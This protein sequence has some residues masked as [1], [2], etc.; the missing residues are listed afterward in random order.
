MIRLQALSRQLTQF[1]S[2]SAFSN[3]TKKMSTATIDTTGFKYNH[4][5]IRIKDPKVSVPFYEKNFGMKLYGK[6]SFT[7]F[8]FDVYYL[9]IESAVPAGTP[10]Y[11]R[12][13]LLELTHNYGT[14]NDEAYTLNNGNKEPHRGFGHICFSVDN[15]EV[16][17]KR[18]EDN[19]IKF[20]KK[21]TDGR[22]KDI[23]FALD[24]D[25]YWI[26]LISNSSVTPKAETTDVTTYKYNHSMIRVKDI[27][28]SLK[29]YQEILGMKLIRTSEHPAAKFTL[30]FLGYTD[31]HDDVPSN[32]EALLELTHNWGTEEDPDFKYH[33]GNEAPQ[34]YGHIGLT[35]PDVAKSM[36][37]F[38]AAG[39]AIKK[40]VTEG[41]MNFIGFI[42]D[43]DNYFIEILP[44]EDL[45]ELKWD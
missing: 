3:A 15:I 32:R 11:K 42:L 17:C 25:G 22:Q 45:P 41:K 23:A 2:V 10:W 4:T 12:E 29:F 1:K 31:G 8:G 14:E 28:A 39:V 40:R 16:A 9:G 13:G 6:Y 19:G 20:Q 35:V 27:K 38:E 7:G 24:P 5:M 26:E 21:L 30:Y 18:L 36:A 43:P 34:G 37:E 33:N 44:S